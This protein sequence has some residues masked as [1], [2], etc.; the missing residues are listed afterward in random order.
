VCTADHGCYPTT[1]STDP[2]REYIPILC[3]GNRVVPRV[4][5]GTRQTFADIAATAAEYFGLDHKRFGTSFYQEIT[6]GKT[7]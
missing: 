5:I 7:T 3:W 4:N 2:S 1:S 6:G